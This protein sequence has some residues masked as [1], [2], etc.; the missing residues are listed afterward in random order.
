MKRKEKWSEPTKP[1]WGHGTQPLIF[2]GVFQKGWHWRGIGPLDSPWPT[3]YRESLQRRGCLD[4]S[5]HGRA[6][7]TWL[8]FKHPR[9][10]WKW[11]FVQGPNEFVIC[12]LICIIYLYIIT[13]RGPACIHS[14]TI[15][16]WF[17]FRVIWGKSPSNRYL[18]RIAGV[19]CLS[20]SL[21]RGPYEFQKNFCDPN[22]AL[23]FLRN[24]FL[25]SAFST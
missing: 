3:H 21:I 16:W 7:R 9:R 19:C 4:R 1:P 23:L 14:L 12:I 20:F 10:W 13:G 11:R 8:D 5:S 22:F 15:N 2:R 6:R 17:K 24:T 25:T 18:R